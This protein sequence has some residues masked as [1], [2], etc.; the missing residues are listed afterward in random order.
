[1]ENPDSRLAP[2]SEAATDEPASPFHLRSGPAASPRPANDPGGDLQSDVLDRYVPV[3]TDALGRNRRSDGF[4]PDRQCVFLEA[5]ARCGVAADACR[6]AGISRDTAYNLRNGAGG[7]AFALG[8]NAA[9]LISRGRLAD[10][11]QSRAL[12]GVVEKI[13][14]N[15]ELWGERHRHDN[16]LAMAVLARLDRQA[17]GLGEGA[18]PARAVAQEWDQFLDLVREA[19][20]GVGDF[21]MGRAALAREAVSDAP[22]PAQAGSAVRLVEGLETAVDGLER[23]FAY[24]IY[25]G[26]LP[27]ET[28]IADLEPAEMAA[29]TNNQWDRAQRGGLLDE[30]KPDDWP[31]AVAEG[32][33][34]TDGD[35]RNRQDIAGPPASDDTEIP[36][37]EQVPGLARARREYRRRAGRI[38]GSLVR[39]GGSANRGATDR[40]EGGSG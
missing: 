27:C 18:I 33:E 1:M 26:G 7:A 32:G 12:N 25:G 29:W 5:L 17:E 34:E 14:R 31:A 39:R 40:S 23:L 4:T 3:A 10:E 20:D 21:L 8:W 22:A 13:Y 11:L 19:D 2:S 16:R 30:L 15:G 9:V 36:Y 38:G 28:D 24:S 37:R 35:C 6:A